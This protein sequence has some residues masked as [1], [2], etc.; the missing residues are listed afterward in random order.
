MIPAPGAG[1][2]GTKK[3]RKRKRPA[4]RGPQTQSSSNPENSAHPK[5]KR[6][7]AKRV[8]EVSAGGLVIDHSGTQGL[9]IGRIDHKDTTGKRILWSLPKGHIEEGETPEQAAIREVAEETGITSSITKSLGVI[10]FWFMAGGKRIHKTVHHFIFT[11]VSGV[12]TPQV[13]E[14]D[15][16]SW[17]PLAEIVDRLAYPD[18]KKLIARSGELT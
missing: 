15:E 13:T 8:D 18:E 16:V 3:K 4:N 10:D 5:N 11:E 6:P 2:E 7:Y 14:V 17:F 12:L 1:S 9:L